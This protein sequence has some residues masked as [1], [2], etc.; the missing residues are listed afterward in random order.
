MESEK[1]L[2]PIDEYLNAGVHVGT[3]FKN[4]SMR[5]YIFKSRP[6]GLKVIDTGLID[7]KLKLLIN[8][9]STYEPT[10]FAVFGRRENSKKPVK[11]FGKVVG[12]DTYPGRYLPGMLTNTELSNFKE[13]KLVILSDPLAD[14]NVLIDAYNTG[15]VIAALCDTN[16]STSM[17]DLVVP[18]NNK[19]K[20]ALALVY[21][22]L[23][24]H[25]LIKR[26]V[27][28]E[29]E[30]SYKLEDFYDE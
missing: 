19:G 3:K 9:L 2:V 11:M 29:K 23:A 28:S 4:G 1:T 20:K 15:I 26:N 24:K 22:L 12:C 27:I 13:Y 14:K 17:V 8:L 16:N 6:D 5:K 10:E 7:K 30:F 25:Y 18:V 21:Y